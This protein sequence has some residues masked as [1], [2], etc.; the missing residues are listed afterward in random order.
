MLNERSGKKKLLTLLRNPDTG[1]KLFTEKGGLVDQ[2]S[3]ER[4]FIREGIPVI[5]RKDDVFGGNRKSQRGYDLG[6]YF[7]D[8]LYATN[9]PGLRKWLAEIAEIIE[10]DSGDCIL[11]T[12]VGTGQQLRNL[13]NHGINGRFFGNDI[14]FGMLK[15]CRKNL[16]KWGIDAGLVQGNAEALPF[17]EEIFDVVF[18]VGGFNFFN[19]KRKAIREMIRVGKPGAKMYLVDESIELIKKQGI[20]SRILPEPDP[21]VYAPPLKH[22]PSE[23]LNLKEY[24]L[25]DRR[26]WMIAFRKPPG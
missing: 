12:S 20:I 17:G 15:K 6:S 25:W 18:H 5:M 1:N 9:L 23:M 7:Y 3:G 16:K 19:D 21:E 26:F 13:K 10:A 2:E 24:N 8:L 11:E 4:F 22:V 14:S